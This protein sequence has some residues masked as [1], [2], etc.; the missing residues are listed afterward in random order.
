[1]QDPMPAAERLRRF[2]QLMLPH[3]DA[4]TNLARWLM[5]AG[6]D[7]RDLVQEAYLRAYRSFDSFQ[8]DTPRAWLLAI[9]RNTCFTARAKARVHQCEESFDDETYEMASEP[10]PGGGSGAAHD[11]LALLERRTEL[12]LLQRLIRTLPDEYREILLLREAE[13]LSYKEIAGILGV[14]VG[15]VMSR[16][17]RARAFLDRKLSAYFGGGSKP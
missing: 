16:L 17:A 5:P 14:P 6:A 13:E 2:E 4:A 1:M 12:E 15:T 8:G 9:V 10:W 11:P 7:A 3:I